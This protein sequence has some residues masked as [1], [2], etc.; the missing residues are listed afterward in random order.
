MGRNVDDIGGIAQ[1]AAN[2]NPLVN[3]RNLRFIDAGG[4]SWT[5][6]D[7]PMNDLVEV[8]AVASGAGVPAGTILPF[9]GTVVPSGYLA[10]DGAAYG[11]TGGDPNPQPTLFAAIGTT[12]GIGDG[13]TTFNVPNFARRTPVG[14][15]G[16]GSGVLGNTVGSTG[17]AET[18]TLT[19]AEMPSHTHGN[20][21]HSHN[22]AQSSPAGFAG[23]KT[24]AP[25]TSPGSSGYNSFLMSGDGS[26][27]SSWTTEVSISIGN[28]GGGGA[29]NNMQPSAV[30]L[31]IIKT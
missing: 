5:V 14:S 27:S 18:H 13:A 7:D 8:T 2:A 12:W 1:T 25:G 17:G 10:C 29:H 28:T 9:G 22:L 24:D 20:S 16:A 23:V 4:I 3:R 31:F 21:N 11:R 15:G 26:L 30:V 6:T 19:Q